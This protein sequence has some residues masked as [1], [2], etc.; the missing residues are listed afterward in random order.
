MFAIYSFKMYSF[1]GLCP[2]CIKCYSSEPVYSRQDRHFLKKFEVFFAPFSHLK[3]GDERDDQ[4]YDEVYV[5][6]VL[7]FCYEIKKV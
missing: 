6:A 5:N 3:F 4:N 1:C 2:E 7:S